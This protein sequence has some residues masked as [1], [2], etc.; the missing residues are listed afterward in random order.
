MPGIF[1]FCNILVSPCLLPI[2]GLIPMSFSATCPQYLAATYSWGL[3]NAHLTNRLRLGVLYPQVI[4]IRRWGA[5]RSA[6]KE[7][8]L[9]EAAL[10]EGWV[11]GRP[12]GRRPGPVR[13][14]GTTVTTG[15]VCEAGPSL[16]AAEGTCVDFGEFTG[17]ET[18][19]QS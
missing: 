14:I 6:A 10:G 18:E 16:K 13:A 11:S 12:W 17:G 15:Q 7:G 3:S 8:F 4:T 1:K 5:L 9:E 2:L 19:A